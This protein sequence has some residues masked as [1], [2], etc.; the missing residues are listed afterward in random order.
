MA[1]LLSNGIEIADPPLALKG[2]VL[3]VSAGYDGGLYTKLTS[4]GAIVNQIKLRDTLLYDHRTLLANVPPEGTTSIVAVGGTG[5]LDMGKVLSRRY[6]LP[7]VLVPTC[8]AGTALSRWAITCAEEIK[9]WQAEPYATYLIPALL[10][11]ATREDAADTYAYAL[12]CY[13]QGVAYVTS[14]WLEGREASTK[15]V[16]KG[17]SALD[18]VLK[19]CDTYTPDVAGT[20]WEGILAV[21]RY[22]P[23][24]VQEAH[25]YSF[26]I[27]LYKRRQILYNKYRFAAAFALGAV[28]KDLPDLPDVILPG[29]VVGTALQLAGRPLPHWADDYPVKQHVWQDYREDIMALEQGL[30]IYAR[31]WRRIVGNCGYGFYDQLTAT[32]LTTCIKGVCHLSPRYSGLSHLYRQGWLDKGGKDGLAK[33][34]IVFDGHGRDGVPGQTGDPRRV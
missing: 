18:E 27:S 1:T 13:Q 7:L 19:A 23:D 21:Q 10:S 24:E 8:Y 5:I 15:S 14:N 22:L 16:L 33:D 17:L 32:D 30:G 2:K 3:L 25:L 31:N 34:Q 26:L 20:L 4:G 28:L 9:I 29:D 11:H 12:S 6:G